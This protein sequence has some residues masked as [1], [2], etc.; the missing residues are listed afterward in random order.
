ME[1]ILNNKNKKD[2]NTIC[3]GG[4]M[5]NN[6]YNQISQINTFDIDNEYEDEYYDEDENNDRE[7]KDHLQDIFEEDYFSYEA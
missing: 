6:I 3:S 1:N 7:Y 5:A 2:E 4:F